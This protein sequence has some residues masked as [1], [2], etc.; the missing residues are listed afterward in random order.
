MKNKLPQ[1][2]TDEEIREQI[3]N[4][5][6]NLSKEKEFPRE[7]IQVLVI[8]DEVKSLA[9]FQSLLRREFNIFT[10]DTA[11]KGKKILETTNIHVLISDQRMPEMTGIAFFQSILKV[12]PDPIRI[13]YTGYSD[14]SAVIDAINKGDVYRYISKPF[15]K[16]E[17]K[18]LIE[19]AYEM[20]YLRKQT[21]KLTRDLAITNRQLEFM[22]RAKLL[23]V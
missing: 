11:L 22:V 5:Y 19:N 3:K 4:F 2:Y 23:D 16:D 7:R 9:A 20:Y 12:H 18:M 8:D 21:E 14:I 15:V 6:T 10:A 13:L 1:D 17:M